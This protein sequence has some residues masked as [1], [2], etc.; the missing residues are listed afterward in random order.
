MRP[1]F[2]L[3]IGY[4]DRF[5]ALA[6]SWPATGIGARSK[7]SVIIDLYERHIETCISRPAIKFLVTAPARPAL[8]AIS[9]RDDVNA[10]LAAKR[11]FQTFLTWVP[12]QIL[13][14]L[15]I[16]R[17][18]PE[19]FPSNSLRNAYRFET[20]L[21]SSAPRVGTRNLEIRLCIFFDRFSL[22]LCL[23]VFHATK[24]EDFFFFL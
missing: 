22:P 19:I 8:P 16:L 11:S 24:E 10:M 13:S 20:S 15:H 12:A 5:S 3:R 17:F 2:F 9:R 23:D 14:R 21:A 1:R 7:H 18:S 6:S 4:A